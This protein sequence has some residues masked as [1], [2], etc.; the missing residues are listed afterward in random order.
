[1]RS[2]IS[3]IRKLILNVKDKRNKKWNIVINMQRDKYFK[4]K[5]QF[6]ISYNW[7]K[8]N[9]S[10]AYIRTAVFPLF[11]KVILL[12]SMD[13]CHKC[14]ANRSRFYY[15]LYHDDHCCRSNRKVLRYVYRRKLRKQRCANRAKSAK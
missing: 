13:F 15:A 9:I 11:S 8:K 4:R 12:L 5:M 7:K 10:E 6:F 2:T 1:M 3:C 14:Y